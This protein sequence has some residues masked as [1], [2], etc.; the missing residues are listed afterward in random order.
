MICPVKEHG[1]VYTKTR[2]LRLSKPNPSHSFDTAEG[3]GCKLIIRRRRE[4][5]IAISTPYNIATTLMMG[6]EW[7]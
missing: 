7:G 1:D 2:L 6:V 4:V 3:T 5:E